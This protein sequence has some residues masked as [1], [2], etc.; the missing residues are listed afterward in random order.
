MDVHRLNFFWIFQ[1]YFF[2]E[3]LRFHRKNGL[4]W[5]FCLP[6]LKERRHMPTCRTERKGIILPLKSLHSWWRRDAEAELRHQHV[7]RAAGPMEASYVWRVGP[8][9]MELGSPRV[10]LRLPP[11]S[12]A[13]AAPA[14]SI[15]WSAICGEPFPA[16]DVVLYQLVRRLL[17]KAVCPERSNIL[18]VAIVN[19]CHSG[20]FLPNL[21]PVPL[22]IANWPWRVT[23]NDDWQATFWRSSL[24]KWI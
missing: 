9:H 21:F 6:I 19:C 10:S 1:L 3:F 11:S 24:P 8:T 16:K 20:K 18:S 2:T 17:S 14:A 22:A 13:T 12:S 15:N 7:T 4:H 23:W 5:I